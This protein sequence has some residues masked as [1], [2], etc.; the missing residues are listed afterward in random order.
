MRSREKPREALAITAP[1]PNCRLSETEVR[2]NG[3]RWSGDIAP[4]SIAPRLGHWNK[5]EAERSREPFSAPECGHGE[6]QPHLSRCATSAPIRSDP[7]TA[8]SSVGRFPRGALARESTDRMRMRGRIGGTCSFSTSPASAACS[9]PAFRSIGTP[10]V[11][12]TTG[13]SPCR[14]DARQTTNETR[15][16]GTR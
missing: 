14:F 11:P 4:G 3:I 1:E 10:G 5:S 9:R 16:C 12:E 6:A 15:F 7:C 2:A 13:N 8:F